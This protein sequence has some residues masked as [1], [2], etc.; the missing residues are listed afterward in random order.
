MRSKT[1]ARDRLLG[2]D[3]PGVRYSILDVLYE[4]LSGDTSQASK[5]ASGQQKVACF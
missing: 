5:Y 3:M 2:K 1:A 4:G